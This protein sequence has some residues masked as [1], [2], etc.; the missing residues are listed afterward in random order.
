[1]QRGTAGSLGGDQPGAAQGRGVR[2]DRRR[3]DSEAARE[4]AG[5][6]CCRPGVPGPLAR[7]SCAP[8]VCGM[9]GMP[10]LAGYV[11]MSGSSCGSAISGQPVQWNVGSRIRPCPSGFRSR[12]VAESSSQTPSRSLLPGTS[13][14]SAAPTPRSAATV[15]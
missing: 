8:T 3:A 4:S 2:G 11:T 10:G 7:A 13:V 6:D 12:A 1:M 14:V 5:G 9:S 15:A